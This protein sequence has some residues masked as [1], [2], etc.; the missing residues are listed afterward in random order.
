VAVLYQGALAHDPTWLPAVT[1]L[2]ALARKSG[3][4]AELV[5]LLRTRLELEQDEA[6]QKAILFEVASLYLGPLDKPGEAVGPL[7]RLVKLSPDDLTV[8]ENLGRALIASGRVEEGE[9]ALGQLVEQLGK[10]RRLKDVAR[11]QYLLGSFA[12]ARGDL[13]VAKQ[14]Y[15]GSYQIDPTQAAVLGA[16]A[17]LSLRQSD[18]E[19]ARRYLRTLLLQTFD[20]KAAGITKA[21]VY[22]ALGNLHKEAG[23][24]AKARNMFERGLETDSRNEA[25]R[26]ALASTPK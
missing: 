3:D 2:E 18:A 12:E 9:F 11:L 6:K 24:N 26:Q 17:R 5:T 14:R 19:A 7:E 16:L 15:T 23:E 8:Q 10:A 13:A 25:L 4:H 20:E 21:E 22:L 1:A